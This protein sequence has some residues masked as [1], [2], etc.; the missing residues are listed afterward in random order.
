MKSLGIEIPIYERFKDD[1]TML[2]Q[3][4]E[5]GSKYEDGALV[6]D[7][8]KKALDEGK[9]EEEITMEVIKNVANSIDEMIKFTVDYPGNNKN[10]KLAILDVEASVNKNNGNKIEFEFYQK[11]IKNKLLI[12][13]N[14]ALPSHQ[15]RT[16]LTQ[17]CLRRLRNTQIELGRDFQMKHLNNFMVEMKNSGYSAKYRK[18]ILDSSEKAFEIMIKDNQSGKKPLYRDKNWNKELRKTQKQEKKLNWYK[19]GGKYNQK[20]NEIDYKT[21]LFVPVT[22]GAILA[23]AV[24]KWKKK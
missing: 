3:S 24:K 17:E 15:K 22:K 11:P 5:A 7:D 23:K 1:I 12:L 16:I 8:D 21:V 14:S 6:M 19:I 13:S 4:L 9:T 10:G 20:K 2:I 18:Q